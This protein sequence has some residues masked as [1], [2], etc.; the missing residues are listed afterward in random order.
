MDVKEK[1]REMKVRYYCQ[2]ILSELTEFIGNAGR[3]LVLTSTFISFIP[4]SLSLFLI[5]S[6]KLDLDLVSFQREKKN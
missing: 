1:N 2:N 6:H 4:T 5:G 3:V